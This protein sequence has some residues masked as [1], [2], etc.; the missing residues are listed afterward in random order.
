MKLVGGDGVIRHFLMDLEMR[1][2]S[3][4]TMASYSYILRLLALALE[5]VCQVTELEQVTVAHLR[6][7]VR[8]LLAQH[9]KIEKSRRPP[10]NGS[11]LAVSTIRGHI[12]VWKVFF[13]WC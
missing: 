11:T 4:H 8:H 9:I 3:P 1:K 2:R 10:A 5:Q 6:Q 7:C 13:N 12:T